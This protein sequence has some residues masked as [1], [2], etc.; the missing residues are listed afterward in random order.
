MILRPLRER[1]TLMLLALLPFHAL[2]L[3]VLTKMIAGQGHA[4]LPWLAAWKEGVLG[5]ILVVAVIEILLISRKRLAVG[6]KRLAIF[7]WDFIDLCI[8][9]LCILGVVIS[10]LHS[11]LSALHSLLG[12]KYDFVPL[13]AFLILRRV[14]WSDRFRDRVLKVIVAV[15]GII[16]GYGILSY[17]LSQDFFVSMGYS[18]LHSL[19]LPDSPIA[20]FQQIGASGMRR[21]QATMSGPNQLGF[22]LL[23]PWTLGLLNIIRG[24][25]WNVWIPYFALVDIALFLTFSRSAW[26][27]ACAIMIV[28]LFLEVGAPFMKKILWG[29]LALFLVATTI[30]ILFAPK[31]IIRSASTS[32]H[33]VRPLRA[34]SMMLAKP[35]G[36]GLGTAG[37]ASNRVSDPCVF[38]PFGADIGW[39]Q[40][41]P[42]LCVFVG[43]FQAQPRDR[44][45][46]C[47]VLP[48]NW[49]LQ[50]GVELG[51]LGFILYVLLIVLLLKR[52]A[53]SG[54]RLAGSPAAS[55]Y[56]LIAFLVFLG[57][58]IGALFL[59]AWEDTAVAYTLW[60][61]IAGILGNVRQ[62]SKL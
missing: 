41:R 54:E 56:A 9:S 62:A 39:A 55:H 31:I 5:I 48:E 3:T 45:C 11:S 8:I 49:Y 50:I 44:A 43:E 25:R 20:A 23:L 4:P 34:V 10:A 29:C 2:L 37:P 46:N 21:I 35:L 38:L 6:D 61:L 13:V 42:E 32:D 28:A 19:Y 47:P 14:E 30:L 58:S 26:V 51:I 22:F 40:N 7:S 18:D 12:F 16:A 15:G 27:A 1:L 36:H 59:H 52:L 57:V 24:E 53:V 17:F 33:L 60:I